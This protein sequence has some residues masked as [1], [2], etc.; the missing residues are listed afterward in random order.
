[1]LVVMYE[2]DLNT[3]HGKNYSKHT[4]IMLTIKKELKNSTKNTLKLMMDLMM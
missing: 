4:L 3:I 1:M 2:K